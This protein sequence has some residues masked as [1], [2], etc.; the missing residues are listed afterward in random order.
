VKARVRRRVRKPPDLT[1]LFDVLFIVV[2][3]A[4][5]RAAAAQQGEAAALAKVADAAPAPP[6]PPTAPD[7][8]ALRARA[9]TALSGE[10]AARIPVVAR[11]SEKGILE[12]LELEGR[13][14]PLDAPLLVHDPDPLIRK[15]YRGD[16]F[17]E[18]QLCRLVA[19]ALHV[20]DLAQHLVIIAPPRPLADLDDALASGL[21]RDLARCA[22]GVATI[23]A[24]PSI[25]DRAPTQP[26]PPTSPA[27]PVAAPGARSSHQ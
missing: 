12:R 4:L 8:A 13:R 16:R 27:P 9:L 3:V 5:I 26:T 17:A 23:V 6:P 10:L 11:V 18:A 21:E 14:V 20:P 1:S 2:F 15:A 22:R 19:Q 24:S 7:V 25:G